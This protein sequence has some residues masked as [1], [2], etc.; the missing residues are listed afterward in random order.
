M[1]VKIVCLASLVLF[2]IASV[3][4]THA[5]EESYTKQAYQKCI[6]SVLQAAINNHKE[7]TSAQGE[8]S[9]SGKPHPPI[10]IIT[11]VRG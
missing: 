3:G 9:V 7:T 10:T 5:E 4:P 1:K 8:R 6:E 2:I 11:G